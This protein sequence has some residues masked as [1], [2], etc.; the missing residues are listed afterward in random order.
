MTL[1]KITHPYYCERM[2]AIQG[3]S[4]ETYGLLLDIGCASG[5]LTKLASQNTI[6]AVG[7]D[8]DVDT[9]KKAEKIDKIGYVMADAHR[10]PYR[11]A[12]FD[13]AICFDVIEHMQNEEVFL[14]E[15]RRILKKDG[16][17]FLTTLNR[18]RLTTLLRKLVGKP[19]RYPHRI[20]KGFHVREY[21]KRELESLLL[22]HGFRIEKSYGFFLGLTFARGSHSIGF[23]RFPKILEGY[24]LGLF[25]KARK[26]V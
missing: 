4:K 2:K 17:L 10:M 12:I 22:S 8:I 20:G 14:Q 6:F 5:H 26:Q 24:C 7:M 21:T 19:R 25:A 9:L 23:S 15:V 1:R 13:C 11:E 16:A 3:A 18:N